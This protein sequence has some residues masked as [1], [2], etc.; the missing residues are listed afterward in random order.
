MA[1][2]VRQIELLQTSQPTEQI[3]RSK[4]VM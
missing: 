2:L 1:I 3:M 4:L